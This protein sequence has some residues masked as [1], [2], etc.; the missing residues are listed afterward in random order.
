LANQP[1]VIL[2]DEPCS[3]LDPAATRQIEELIVDLKQRYTIII[4]T[5]NL[6]QANRVADRAIFMLDGA[7]IESGTKNQIFTRPKSQLTWEFVSGQ[8]G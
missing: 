4:V 8:S 5:H 7:I 1:Q 3:S 2:M 6:A